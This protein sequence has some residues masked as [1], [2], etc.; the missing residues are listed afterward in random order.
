MAVNQAPLILL[1][2]QAEMDQVETP[3]QEQVRVQALLQVQVFLQTPLQAR[4]LRQLLVAE[5]KSK[6]EVPAY[7]QEPMAGTEKIVSAARITNFGIQR[8]KLATIPA[9]QEWSQ[10][11]MAL[12]RA[13]L[14]ANLGMELNV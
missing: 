4:A 7:V 9:P 14:P 2:E 3:D 11:L 10:S 13:V 1:Q 6:S 8:L 5:D 12:A